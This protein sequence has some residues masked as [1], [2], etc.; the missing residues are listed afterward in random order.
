M[1][2]ANV[3]LDIRAFDKDGNPVNQ[4]SAARDAV[5]WEF[6]KIGTGEAVSGFGPGED[7]R[8]IKNDQ[9]KDVDPKVKKTP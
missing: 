2:L 8:I 5:W 1:Q 9:K 7:P 4:S 6:Y 3:G